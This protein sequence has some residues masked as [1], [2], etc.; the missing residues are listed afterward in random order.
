M[1]K[2]GAEKKQLQAGWGAVLKK[3]GERV[4][5]FEASDHSQTIPV[6]TRAGEVVE[7]YDV[8]ERN[9]DMP[10]TCDA[11]DGAKV[12]FNVSIIWKITRIG[13]YLDRARSPEEILDRAARAALTSEAVERNVEQITPS[14]T[15]IADNVRTML[16]S[17]MDHYGVSVSAIHI[18]NVELLKPAKPEEKKEEK[19]R[20]E[21]PFDLKT[22]HAEMP[23]STQQ[24]TRQEG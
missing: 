1:P 5:I 4:R 7:H 12:T 3:Q 20:E 13:D 23:T 22:S 6:K 8:R 16:N 19:K 21:T 15:Q 11:K 9:T 17:S 14:L 2:V 18:T 24:R 10:H